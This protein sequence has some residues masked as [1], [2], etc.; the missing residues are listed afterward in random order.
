MDISPPGDSTGTAPGAPT[1]VVELT[2]RARLLASTGSRRILGITGA[3][4]A[5]KS[6]V[7]AQLVQALGSETAV[8]VPMDG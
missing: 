8:L 5:G 3:P 4:G 2:A 6:T 1:T 7:A